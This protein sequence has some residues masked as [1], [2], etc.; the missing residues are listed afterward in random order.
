MLQTQLQG[1]NG[2]KNIADDIIV[3]GKTREEHDENLDRCLTCL[4]QRGLTLNKGKCKFLS[5]ILEFFGQIF[6]KEGT[7]PDPKRVK[8]LLNA[9]VPKDICDVHSLSGMA[10]YSSKYIKNFATITAPLRELT[11]KDTR[12]E[13]KQ[14]HQEAFTKLTKALS[15]A[16]CMSYFDKHKDTYILVDANPVGLCANLS[17]KSQGSEDQKV[18]AYAS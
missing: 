1:L 17:Q 14:I 10:N 4:K 5:N 7:R 12:F 11:K 3:Y 15:T 6:S 2:V 9:Q 16:P 18:V 8:D 13:W